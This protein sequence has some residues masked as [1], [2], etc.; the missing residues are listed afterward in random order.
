MTNWNILLESTTDGQTIATV[1]ELP[2]FQVTAT[3]RQLALDKI[4]QLLTQRLSKT[5]VVSLPIP[6]N[7]ETNP[8]IKFGGIYKGDSDFTHI[9]EPARKQSLL[10]VIATLTGIEEEFPD[11]DSDLLPLD[12]INI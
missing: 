1:I 7:P 9:V 3:T 12:D 8:W 10:E 2:T 11:V 6:D 4:Q 5:E